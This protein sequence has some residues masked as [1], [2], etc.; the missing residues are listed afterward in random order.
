MLRRGL[1]RDYGSAI[2]VVTRVIDILLVFVSGWLAYLVRFGMHFEARSSIAYVIL[3]IIIALLVGLIFPLLSVYVSWRARGIWAPAARVLLAWSAVYICALVIM[4]ITHKTDLY[5][6]LWLGYWALF[7]ALLIGL[8]FGIYWFL[9]TLRRRGYNRRG[10]AIVGAN[11]QGRLLSDHIRSADWSGLDVLGLFDNDENLPEDSDPA[12]NFYPLDQLPNF[13]TNHQVQEVWVT[14]PL[15]QG[16]RLRQILAW[17]NT[18]SVNIRYSPDLFGMSLLNNGVTE[19][20]GIPMID[21]STTPMQ[22]INRLLKGLEDRLLA[23]LILILA[24]PLMLLIAIAIKVTSPGP[25]LFYQRRHGWDGREISVCKF[26]TMY[27]HLEPGAPTQASRQDARI[28][29]LGRLLRRLSLD[30]LP[31]FFNVL[32]GRMSIVGPRPHAIEHNAQ[33]CDLS[34]RYMLRHKVKPGIT[35]WAQVN[36]W[37]GKTDTLEKMEKRIEHDLYYIEHWSLGFDLR[38]IFL[39][40]LFG[41]VHRN[42]CIMRMLGNVNSDQN[43]WHIRATLVG[44]SHLR[45]LQGIIGVDINDSDANG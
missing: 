38:I 9:H 6:R 37:R 23:S 27:V 20:V 43:R 5:S 7:T 32:Q 42:E 21:L 8:R 36:G 18:T 41:F 30:E 29:P 12:I 10:V 15:E 11:Q 28:T 2:S 40:I 33:Y 22:G 13:I 25:V 34:D 19:I 3:T 14:I 24:S 1:L 4:V 35:G 17:L 39:T 16:G 31:Q 44:V 45:L 26:R